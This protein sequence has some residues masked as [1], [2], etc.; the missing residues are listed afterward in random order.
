[1]Q[2]C[3]LLVYGC[4]TGHTTRRSVCCH[5]RH[6]ILDF[7]EGTIEHDW[8]SW[9][10]HVYRWLCGHCHE[11]TTAV[12]CHNHTRD[13]VFCHS[14]WFLDVRWDYHSFVCIYR[15]LGRAPI[16]K[17]EHV[18]ISEHLQFDRRSKCGG[19]PRAGCRRCYSDWGHSAIQSM[20]LIFLACLRDCDSAHRDYLLECKSNTESMFLKRLT[21]CPY[22]HRKP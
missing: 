1:M 18:G 22:N 21:D 12:V 20:V 5:H 17:E 13:E 9:M 15:V 16:R 14:T 10:L 8:E 7:F 3:R 11:R 6:S 2:L 19:Y 4:Y